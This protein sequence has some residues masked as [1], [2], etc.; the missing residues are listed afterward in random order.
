MLRSVLVALD[1]SPYSEPATRLAIDW[2]GRFSAR[3]VGLGVLDEPSIR[4]GEPVPLGAGAYK[5][6]RDEARLAEAHRRVLDFLANFLA[7][8]AAARVAA[9]VLEDVGDPADRIL[10]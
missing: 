7:R 9:E 10:R 2:A 3:L 6:A 4:G 1:G 5:R 8:A